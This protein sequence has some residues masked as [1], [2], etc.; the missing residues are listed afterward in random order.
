MAWLLVA[1]VALLATSC[2]NEENVPGTDGS[3]MI[4]FTVN[5][6]PGVQ[7]RTATGSILPSG[8][9]KVLRYMMEVY[10][11][12]GALVPNS[13]TV[14]TVTDE[15]APVT[16]TWY[17]EEGATYHVVFWADITGADKA[18]V[19]YDTSTGLKG[20]TFN[21]G[22]TT[23]FYGEAFYGNA[24]I[25]SSEAAA[26]SVTLKHAVSVVKL[27]T[28]AALEKMGSVK[29]TYGDPGNTNAPMSTFDA[30]TG[31]ASTQGTIAEKVNTVDPTQVAT[32]ADPYDFHT[33]YVFAPSDNQALIT[34]KIEMCSDASGTAVLKTSSVS[35]VPIRTNYQTNITG[36]FGL[37]KDTY[38][39]TCDPT[40]GGKLRPFSL[41]DGTPATVDA[42]YT[43]GDATKDGSTAEKAYVIASATD[44]VQLR[45]NVN[46]GTNYA[47]KY[48]KQ[49]IDIDLNNI[50]WDRIGSES[51]PFNGHYDGNGHTVTNM[52]VV[53][54]FSAGMFG[55]VKG[56]NLSLKNIHVSGTIS[57]GQS[58]GICGYFEGNSSSALN[59]R[60]ISGCSFS[61]EITLGGSEMAGIC[62]IAKNAIITSCANYGN[63]RLTQDNG[64]I[65]SGI[66]GTATNCI[67]AGCYNA[68]A[69]D[70]TYS[71]GDG[72]IL[73]GGISSD[74]SNIGCYNI[75]TIN[76][77]NVKVNGEFS[78]GVNNTDCYAKEPI[79]INSSPFANGVTAFSSSWI[80]D[81]NGTW[82]A[83]SDANGSYTYNSD[84]QAFSNC[85]FW[86]SLG[87][88]N[89][90]GN[91]VVYPKLWWEE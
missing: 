81:T 38:T 32:E 82:A 16:F 62:A 10:D 12:S 1:F 58:A 53:L 4:T 6:D 40:W 35:N 9:N 15:S 2:S 75:G 27:K 78:I 74:G 88:W 49:T 84:T 47:G 18:D 28:T 72:D 34:M 70:Y 8:G 59:D 14:Q 29:V 60:E 89:T 37:G 24:D 61:G 11:S 63:I 39:V 80:T 17:K 90:G 67:I 36:N 55:C 71:A 54:S 79:T 73:L 7:T 25:N 43:F 77:T 13:R 30:S 69:L 57:G 33:F 65:I 44:L 48:F 22:N 76:M 50:P 87:S 56:D 51:N 23:D 91:T 19:Y 5:P 85:K 64:S 20:V 83:A 21:S 52:K 42:S 26:T 66:V 45:A 46:A 31:T 3:K 41:W 68:G 86:K